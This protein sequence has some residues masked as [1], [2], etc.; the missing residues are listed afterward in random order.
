[1]YKHTVTPRN[2]LIVQTICHT[3][4]PQHCTDTL[5]LQGTSPLYSDTVTPRNFIIVLTHYQT[6]E[7][8]HCTDTLSH[9]GTSPLSLHI[10]T[11][12]NLTTVHCI[13]THCHTFC[14]HSCTDILLIQIQALVTLEPMLAFPEELD[15]QSS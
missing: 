15:Q 14:P 11:T 3:Q 6:Q 12:G 1:M 8:P 2:L 5:S 9:P 4:E 10:V 13:L 7:P